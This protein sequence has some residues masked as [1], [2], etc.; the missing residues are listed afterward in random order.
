MDF[1]IAGKNRLETGF[2]RNY[3]S[4]D[5]EIGGRNDFEL[6]FLKDE[7]L[8]GHINFGTY[9]F[10]PGTEYGGLIE[11]LEMSAKSN[12]IKWYGNIWRG[13]LS[14]IVI[15]PDTDEEKIHLT[16]DANQIIGNILK[17]KM[18]GLFRTPSYNSEINIDGTIDAY[19]NVLEGISELLSEHNAKLHIHAEQGGTDGAFAV[20][21]EAVPIK[22]YSEEIEYSE[23]GKINLSL[24]DFRRGINH[25]ICLGKDEEKNTATVHLY[26]QLD[27]SIATKKYYEGLSERTAVYRDNNAQKVSALIDNG[28]K[29]LRE[30]M[31][32][33]KLEMNVQDVDL[34]VGD[35]IAGRDRKMGIY[36]KKPVIQKI[37]SI[38]GRN[39]KI[40]YKVKG[41]D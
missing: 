41:E 10:V 32:Y 6:V 24:R 36:L 12:M 22:D 33:K 25:L 20:I 5:L 27:G 1:L 11:D 15:E 7:P 9:I 19:C 26:A 8:A 16:G 40:Q 30:L 37:V 28:K 21:V 4:I 34:S 38:R 31:N 23:D 18:G 39:E 35:I 2:L 17:N 3:K 14:Q 29:K 13:I